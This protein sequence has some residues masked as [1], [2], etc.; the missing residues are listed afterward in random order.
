LTESLIDLGLEDFIVGVTDFCVVED[1]S[2]ITRVGG[3]KSP[4][5]ETILSLKPDLV[6]ANMEETSRQSVEALESEG[7]NVW[8]TFPK[9]VQEA[10]SVLRAVMDLFHVKDSVERIA[11]LELALDWTKRA[12]SERVKAFC[13]IWY[14][15]E[16]DWLMTFNKD[17][18]AHDVLR[19]CGGDNV[20]ADR[21]RQYPLAADLGQA[22]AEPAGDRDT[23]YPRVTIQEIVATDPEVILLP[24]EP[25]SFDEAHAEQLADRLQGIRAIEANRIH[26]VD[27]RL[28]TWHGTRLGSALTELPEF[29]QPVL[30]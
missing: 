9:S 21:E 24:S 30:S 5:L 8:V 27:G 16:Q 29:L 18:Y 7:L 13:P 1:E 12:T 6:L 10:I 22:E 17:T 4:K 28:I 11:T 2:E 19:H 23:R 20:F 25:F 15:P 3:T 14:E 26:L